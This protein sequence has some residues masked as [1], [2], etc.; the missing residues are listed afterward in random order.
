MQEEQTSE[1]GSKNEVV[2][3]N[4]KEAM[5]STSTGDE[6]DGAERKPVRQGRLMGRRVGANR[7]GKEKDDKEEDDD[8]KTAPTT[9]SQSKD[10]D[11]YDGRSS[12]DDSSITSSDVS[13]DQ[14]QEKKKEKGDE[15]EP[16]NDATVSTEK[17]VDKVE[18]KKGEQGAGEAKPSTTTTTSRVAAATRRATGTRQTSARRLASRGLSS[19]ALNR[20]GTAATKAA[21]AGSSSAAGAGRRAASR[22]SVTATSG[23]SSVRATTKAAATPAGASAAS[24]NASADG[25]TAAAAT[26]TA[27]TA[28]TAATTRTSSA[29]I[30]SEAR[31][32]WIKNKTNKMKDDTVT[33]RKRREERR[34]NRT[35]MANRRSAGSVASSSSN[36][37]DDDDIVAEI[38]GDGDN[39]TNNKMNLKREDSVNLTSIFASGGLAE[40]EAGDENKAE[41]KESNDDDE[42]PPVTHSLSILQSSWL[43]RRFNSSTASGAGLES[44]DE[45]S[46]NTAPTGTATTKAAPRRRF[47][48]FTRN[49]IEEDKPMPDG[50]VDTGIASS[51]NNNS[52]WKQRLR[53][54]AH[55]TKVQAHITKLNAD[56]RRYEYQMQQHKQAFGVDAYDK[57]LEFNKAQNTGNIVASAADDSYVNEL[58][59]KCVQDI[60]DIRNGNGDNDDDGNTQKKEQTLA[61]KANKE[62]QRRKE[63]MQS[64]E[65]TNNLMSYSDDDEDILNIEEPEALSGGHNDEETDQ[66]NDNTKALTYLE[67]KRIEQECTVRKEQFGIALYD[68]MYNNQVGSDEDSGNESGDEYWKVLKEIFTTTKDKIHIPKQQKAIAEREIT[69]LETSGAVLATKEEISNLIVSHPSMYAMLGVIMNEIMDLSEVDCQQIAISVATELIGSMSADL[70]PKDE[71]EQETLNGEEAE[72]E[73]QPTKPKVLLTKRSYMNFERDYVSNPKGE[74]EFFH[75]CVFA[76]FAMSIDKN[77]GQKDKESSSTTTPSLTVDQ[78]KQFIETLFDS[79]TLGCSTASNK[80]DLLNTISNLE[81]TEKKEAAVVADGESTETGNDNDSVQAST[82]TFDHVRK[83]ITY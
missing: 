72:E 36:S 73:K 80:N 61:E 60:R 56:I 44:D 31:L 47:G 74:Q 67:T 33:V 58:F 81:E 83:F 69:D 43:R 41:K 53:V 27:T 7:S 79:G 68:A 3:E 55:K 6:G 54:A 65:G 70:I 30:S 15:K 2:F 24:T 48:W 19:R 62:E 9:T 76:A 75:R 82:Y 40:D 12:G 57:L 78:L 45:A 28:T 18:E 22:R 20:S 8:A 25:N 39:N 37:S 38:V 50:D 59:V 23:R 46:I 34:Q 4:L 16:P 77:A 26:T 1:S 64:L 10:T 29:S 52:N 17:Q 5:P 14:D 21:G 51:S 49:T 63:I 35:R 66:Q 71:E 11:N 42:A 13:D 32:D